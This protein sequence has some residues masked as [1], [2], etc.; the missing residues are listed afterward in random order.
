MKDVKQLMIVTPMPETF[1][2]DTSDITQ[3]YDKELLL[4]SG[5]S[6]VK[7]KPF[8]KTVSS[9]FAS[10]IKVDFTHVDSQDDIVKFVSFYVPHRDT[11]V[12]D[13]L[14]VNGFG[15]GYYPRI[16]IN[17][18]LELFDEDFHVKGRVKWREDDKNGQF[19]TIKPTRLSYATKNK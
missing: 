2:C 14:M 10:P 4:T 16:E 3:I 9:L 5:K 1:S 17:D 12:S 6:T 7:C 19:V 11:N 13:T 18:L 8:G 15:Y